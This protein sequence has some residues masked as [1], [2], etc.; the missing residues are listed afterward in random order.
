MGRWFIHDSFTVMSGELRTLHATKSPHP[1]MSIRNQPSPKPMQNMTL[2]RRLIFPL[3]RVF[4]FAYRSPMSMHYCKQGAV[5]PT[6]YVVT[7]KRCARQIPTG[8]N[9]FPRENL[10]VPCPLCGELRRF[11]PSEI[12]LGF[13]DSLI[14]VQQTT[15]TRRRRGGW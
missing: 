2:P 13:P 7:C 8:V 5:K 14:Q 11:R 12:F 3:A 9:A 6:H 4:I 10:V 15:I 1:A